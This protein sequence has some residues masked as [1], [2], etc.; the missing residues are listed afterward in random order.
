[1]EGFSTSQYTER[2]GRPPPPCYLH[3]SGPPACWTGTPLGCGPPARPQAHWPL[4]HRLSATGG[5]Q[6]HQTPAPNLPRRC[7]QTALDAKRVTPELLRLKFYCSCT[8]D[9]FFFSLRV[10]LSCSLFNYPPSLP[11]DFSGSPFFFSL[12]FFFPLLSFF[13]IFTIVSELILNYT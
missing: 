2:T 3:H 4:P 8:R 12:F 1:V 9:F 11:V 6:H 13:V 10:C 5:L 7:R